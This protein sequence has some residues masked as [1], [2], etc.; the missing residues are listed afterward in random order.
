MKIT[1]LGLGGA[2]VIL[3]FGVHGDVLDA[4][5]LSALG[6]HCTT[7]QA[8]RACRALVW[9]PPAFKALLLRFPV[10]YQNMIPKLSESLLE[11]EERFREVA[12]EKVGA[13]VAR[14]IVRLSSQIGRR[15]DGAIEIGLSR[16][17]L[18]QMTGTTLFTVSR[19]V[20]AWEARGIV[21]NARGSVTICDLASL[22][23]VSD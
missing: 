22:C 2:E 12:T 5:S 11:L 13:R 10:L 3:R 21:R 7:A 16:E 20:S 14:Q 9:D 23:A 19:L 18:A 1:Q 6:T 15:V 17:E 8:F 4:V